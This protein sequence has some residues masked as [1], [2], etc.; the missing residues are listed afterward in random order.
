[1]RGGSTGGVRPRNRFIRGI[2]GLKGD[3]RFSP[4]GG[5]FAF[6]EVGRPGSSS[7]G[8]KGR[9]V[10]SKNPAAPVKQTS[11]NDEIAKLRLAEMK[12]PLSVQ[13]AET[14]A[15]SAAKAGGTQMS[16]ALV[17]NAVVPAVAYAYNKVAPEVLPAARHVFRAV[18]P[19][20]DVIKAYGRHQLQQIGHAAAVIGPALNA[21]GHPA[22]GLVDAARDLIGCYKIIRLLFLF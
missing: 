21:I 8:K 20:W 5:S 2:S 12:K 13:L 9:F 1:M 22:G 18:P 15:S 4:F 10:Q 7:F 19:L 11:A 6:S 16:T 14:F 3:K 17:K